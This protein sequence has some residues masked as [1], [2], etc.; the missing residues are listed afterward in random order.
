M[1]KYIKRFAKLF[2]ESMKEIQRNSP[3]PS[4]YT[5]HW[6]GYFAY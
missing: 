3:M 2:E 5:R 6:Y 4:M 1:K